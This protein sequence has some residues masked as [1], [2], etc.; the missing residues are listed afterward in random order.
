MGLPRGRI[1][2]RAQ[3]PW[4]GRFLSR[5]LQFDIAFR[6][7]YGAALIWC[8]LPAG[9]P[10]LAPI[11]P[12]HLSRV[13]FRQPLCG[14]SFLRQSAYEDQPRAYTQGIPVQ[15]LLSPWEGRSPAV[16][17]HSGTP[18]GRHSVETSDRG[19]GSIYH[20][21]VRAHYRQPSSMYFF[22]S[23]SRPWCRI[24]VSR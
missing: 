20:K 21:C 9:A 16:H 22:H 12:C 6:A 23:I 10:M 8:S 4:L 24:R 17:V 18:A 7:P 5:M 1:V 11:S 13:L 2:S 15:S 3:V 14:H 19:S